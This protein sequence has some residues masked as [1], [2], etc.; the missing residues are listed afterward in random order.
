M[1]DNIHTIYNT[2]SK[3]KNLTIVLNT[4]LIFKI[5]LIRQLPLSLRKW[6]MDK[7]AERYKY[8]SF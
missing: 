5:I 3:C 7:M 1:D 2:K 4:I 8:L 6:N